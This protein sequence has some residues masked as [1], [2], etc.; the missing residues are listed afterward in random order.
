MQYFP[1][2]PPTLKHLNVSSHFGRPVHDV[3]IQPTR[4]FASY[5]QSCF[6]IRFSELLLALPFFISLY[7]T[8]RGNN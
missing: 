5:T 7:K 1:K 2:L 6:G 3:F 8:L 4:L